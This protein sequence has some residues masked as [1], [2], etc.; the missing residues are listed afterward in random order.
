MPYIYPSR[1]N[2]KKPIRTRSERVFSDTACSK[3]ASGAVSKASL[4]VQISE[5][6]QTI[7]YPVILSKHKYKERIQV[8]KRRADLYSF[9]FYKQGD[10]I[11]TSPRQTI[12]MLRKSQGRASCDILSTRTCLPSTVGKFFSNRLTRVLII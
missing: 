6:S 9:L 10:C 8:G 3:F 7:Y 5:F 11:H 12:G 4:S 1:V 2:S